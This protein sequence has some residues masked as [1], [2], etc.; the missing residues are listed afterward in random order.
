MLP[1]I[2]Q[3]VSDMFHLT[4]TFGSIFISL[5][6]DVAVNFY[7]HSECR[8]PVVGA[9]CSEVVTKTDQAASC[10]NKF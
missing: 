6:C 9:G 8:Y 5:C 7:W 3:K 2:K 1:G 4:L 10:C